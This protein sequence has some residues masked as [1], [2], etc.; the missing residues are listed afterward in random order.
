MNMS[1]KSDQVKETV[2]QRFIFSYEFRHP[3]V[4]LIS[5]EGDVPATARIGEE[6]SVTDD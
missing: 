5:E 2:S 3:K 4:I 1:P 6:V